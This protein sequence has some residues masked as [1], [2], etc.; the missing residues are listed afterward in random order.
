MPHPSVEFANVSAFLSISA[1]LAEGDNV[2]VCAQKLQ[3]QADNLVE[4]HIATINE[5]ERAKATSSKA[6]NATA[7]KADELAAKHE[8]RRSGGR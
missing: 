1:D 8:A 3:T 7:T 4:K 6:A 5:R 2:A